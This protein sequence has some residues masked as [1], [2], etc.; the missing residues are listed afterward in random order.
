M[1]YAISYTPVDTAAVDAYSLDGMLRFTGILALI[2]SVL[3]AGVTV[4]PRGALSCSMALQAQ[5]DCCAKGSGLHRVNCCGQAGQQPSRVVGSGII[6]QHQTG[7]MHL[8]GATVALATG[9]AEPKAAILNRLRLDCG[10][11]PP[12]TPLSHH[13]LLLL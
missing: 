10:P 11:A 2:L 5:H 6:N 1:P 12:S 3:L 13:T 9:A 7:V 4:C 8:A